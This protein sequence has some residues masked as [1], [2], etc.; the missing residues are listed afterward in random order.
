[1]VGVWLGLRK[2]EVSKSSRLVQLGTSGIPISIG[3]P[4]EA[5]RFAEF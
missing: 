5:S 1:M 3:P 4:Y 2:V